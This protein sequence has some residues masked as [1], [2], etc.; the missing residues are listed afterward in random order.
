MLGPAHDWII[1]VDDESSHWCAWCSSLDISIEEPT[2]IALLA[3][4]RNIDEARGLLEPG[5]GIAKL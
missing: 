4:I 2:R 1:W 5:T 3:R